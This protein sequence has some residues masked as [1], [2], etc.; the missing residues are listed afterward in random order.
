M[1]KEGHALKKY[2]HMYLEGTQSP[3][4]GATAVKMQRLN[5][6]LSGQMTMANTDIATSTFIEALV[7]TLVEQQSTLDQ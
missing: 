2:N 3:C 1:Q 4:T 5:F 6:T 7:A